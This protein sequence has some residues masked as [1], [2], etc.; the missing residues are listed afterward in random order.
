MTPAQLLLLIQ[1]D[2][3][4]LALATAGN[5]E[6]CALRCMAIAPLID[7]SKRCT[8]LDF[9]ENAPLAKV[10]EA[11]AKIEAVAATNTSVKRM[12]KFMQPGAEGV[13]FSRA[14]FQNLI[15]DAPPNGCGLTAAQAKTLTDLTKVSEIINAAMVGEAMKPLRGAA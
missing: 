5:D 11:M 9:M 10:E 8:E 1:S 12:L 15:T 7:Q 3:T 6:A 4:A 13:D 14:K 2:P